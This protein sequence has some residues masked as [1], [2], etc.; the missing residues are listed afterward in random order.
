MTL[1]FPIPEWLPWWVPLALALPLGLYALALIFMPFAVLG[2]KSRLEA[3]ELR[4]DEIQ[5]EIRSLALR[6]PEPMRDAADFDDSYVNPPPRAQ[7]AEPV[8]LRPPIPPA[9]H[10]TVEPLAAVDR[11][12]ASVRRGEDRRGED[13]R[14]SPLHEADHGRAEPRLN[15]PR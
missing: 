9:P 11:R 6:L 3:I 4:L 15:W 10:P 2:T 5:G 12:L 14:P 8:S 1:P 7:R 13:R